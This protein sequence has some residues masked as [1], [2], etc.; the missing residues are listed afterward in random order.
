MV[1]AFYRWIFHS[2]KSQPL[3]V[4]TFGEGSLWTPTEDFPLWRQSHLAAT[5]KN[6]WKIDHFITSHLYSSSW[7]QIINNFVTSDERVTSHPVGGLIAGSLRPVSKWEEKWRT[8]QQSRS[9]GWHWVKWIKLIDSDF[10]SK[11]L[12]VTAVGW[13]KN[14]WR[15]LR[16]WSLGESRARLPSWVVKWN[17]YTTSWLNSRWILQWKISDSSFHFSVRIFLIRSPDFQFQN[18]H[19]SGDFVMKFNVITIIRMFTIWVKFHSVVRSRCPTW[20][21]CRFFW[22]FDSFA[23]LGEPVCRVFVFVLFFFKKKKRIG[24]LIFES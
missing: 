1:A 24:K 16:E 21:R 15:T 13:K 5:W 9:L 4:K 18:P 17:N 7:W 11:T 14:I 23:T 3:F 2:S 8:L 20:Q 6:V 10:V 12:K 22:K 19:R